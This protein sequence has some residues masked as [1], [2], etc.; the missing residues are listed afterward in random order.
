[1]LV[2]VSDGLGSFVPTRA[3]GFACPAVSPCSRPRESRL[4]QKPGWVPWDG[5]LCC[6]AL[7]PS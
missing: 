6:A 2:T 1:M 7:G 5:G 3:Q 4:L